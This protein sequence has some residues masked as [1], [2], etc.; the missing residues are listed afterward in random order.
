[1]CAHFAQYTLNHKAASILKLGEKGLLII[2]YEEHIP[3]SSSSSVLPQLLYKHAAENLF[4]RTAATP[5]KRAAANTST[6]LPKTSS[7]AQPQLLFKCTAAT[8]L[9]ARCRK[10]SSSALLQLLLK[11]T[12]ETRLKAHCRNSSSRELP[13]IIFKRADKTTLQAFYNFYA[14]FI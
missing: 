8:P 5:L 13:Q 1:L 14:T 7:S 10:S 2:G 11:C 6:T 9:Q 4:K 12:A 3:E